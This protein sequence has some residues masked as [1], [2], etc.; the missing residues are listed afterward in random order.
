VLNHESWSASLSTDFF[1]G[2]RLF[3]DV[4]MAAGGRG[5]QPSQGA[6]FYA[7][8]NCIGNRAEWHPGTHLSVQIVTISPRPKIYKNAS[9]RSLRRE[10]RP[11]STTTDPRHSAF[12]IVSHVTYTLPLK[13]I[14]RSDKRLFRLPFNHVSFLTALAIACA[15]TT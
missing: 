15:H 2:S 8:P 1:D 7:W 5:H 12:D 9:A 4:V 10:T 13:R 14:L 6:D 3:S 11:P